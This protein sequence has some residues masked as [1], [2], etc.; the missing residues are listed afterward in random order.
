MDQATGLLLVAQTMDWIRDQARSLISAGKRKGIRN[1]RFW[2]HMFS[3]KFGQLYEAR[4]GADS[5]WR[6]LILA[7]EEPTT[8]FF[9][10]TGIDLNDAA[11]TY[12]NAIST[13]AKVGFKAGNLDFF[14]KTIPPIAVEWKGPG[15]YSQRGITEAIL[16]LFSE[17]HV[18]AAR[19]F[20]AIVTTNPRGDAKHRHLMANRCHIAVNFAKQ[21]LTWPLAVD[22]KLYVY[23]GAIYMRPGRPAEETVAWGA[24]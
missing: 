5:Y 19:V 24:Y 1:E 11:A 6:D 3:W 23:A 8:K 20:A 16:K 2:H 10:R 9:R 7:P 4:C 13:I 22:P 14:I 15:L 18:G 21:V 12:Q 17:P